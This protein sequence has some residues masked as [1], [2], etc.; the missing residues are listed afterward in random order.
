[1]DALFGTVIKQQRFE[2]DTFAF[3]VEHETDS[4]TFYLTDKKDGKMYV[5]V[6]TNEK[7]DG[8]DKLQ[9]FRH[10]FFDNIVSFDIVD[11]GTTLRNIVYKD[12]NVV[13]MRVRVRSGFDI[14]PYNKEEYATTEQKLIAYFDEQQPN[15]IDALK[16]CC[17]DKNNFADMPER[18]L[19][20]TKDIPHT[21]KSI[22]EE[23]KAIG[24]KY[25]GNIRHPLGRKVVLLREELEEL[26][27]NVVT[28]QKH[29]LKDVRDYYISNLNVIKRNGNITKTNIEK[30]AKNH[31]YEN[32]NGDKWHMAMGCMLSYWSFKISNFKLQNKTNTSFDSKFTNIYEYIISLLPPPTI[33]V[34]KF[35]KIFTDPNDTYKIAKQL[36]AINPKFKYENLMKIYDWIDTSYIDLDSNDTPER[37]YV[38]NTLQKKLDEIEFNEIMEAK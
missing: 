31:Y 32:T 12:K 23:A 3:D 18:V 4:L 9:H 29:R 6:V 19:I 11:S 7:S 5:R 38:H 21:L 30:I 36:V 13:D 16:N 15:I 28:T 20:P 37:G 22:F 34:G 24:G 2:T 10:N 25:C 27:K 14:Y 26:E 8:Y 17:F 1:M 35:A 33:K